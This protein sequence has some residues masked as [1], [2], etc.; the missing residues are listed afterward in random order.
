[1]SDSS[2]SQSSPAESLQPVDPYARISQLTQAAFTSEVLRKVNDVILPLNDRGSGPAFYCVHSIAGA[3]T[4]FRFMAHMLGPNQRFYGIQTPTKKRN[5][6]FPISIESIS[7]YYVDRLVKFQPEGSFVLGGHSVGSMV[8]LEM[9]Q[10][11]CARGR[12]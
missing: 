12:E 4:D 8:A 9:A 11:L 2:F 3:A 7:E 1:M 6:E 5:A 10:Q